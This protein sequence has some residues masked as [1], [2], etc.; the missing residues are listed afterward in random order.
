MAVIT[1]Q[2]RITYAGDNVSTVLAVPFEF[3]FAADLLVF[4]Q[5]VATGAYSALTLGT[6]YTAQNAGNPAGG[7]ITMTV[8]IVG[9]YNYSIIL[10]PTLTQQSNYP[11]NSPFPSG[12]VQNDFDRHMQISQRLLDQINRSIRAP[13]ADV[14]PGMLL[15]P[16]AQ[17]ISQ[18]LATDGAGN[19]I[20]TA[21]LPGTANT[22]ASLGPILNPQTAAEGIAGV[23]PTNFLFPPCYVDRYAINTTPGTTDM[24]PAFNAA[25]KVALVAGGRI[26]YGASGQYGVSSPINFTSGAGVASFGITV[27]CET[28]F[29]PGNLPGPSIVPN[30]T[31]HVIDLT[32]SLG[33]V[34][35]NVSIGNGSAIPKTGFFQS[36]LVAG[37]S[38][39]LCRFRNCST[40]G[41]FS[42]AAYY[43]YGAED[44]QL[45]DCYW[46]NSST[47]ANA[48]CIAWTGSNY[49]ALTSTFQTV[50]TGTVSSIDHKVFGGEIYMQSNT[51]TADCIHLEQSHSLK[52]YGPWMLCGTPSSGGGRSLIYVDMTN[53]GPAPSWV[54]LKNITGEENGVNVQQYGI[55]FSNNN[56]TPSTWD[57]DS[58]KLTNLSNT[59]A[60]G[61]AN[62]ILD[63]FRIRNIS[64]Q[65]GGAGLSV[66]ALQNS[67]VEG[68]PMALTIGISTKNVLRGFSDGWTIGTRV[69]DFWIDQGSGNKTIATVG[70]SGGITSSAGALIARARLS[71]NGPCLTFN[72]VLGSTSG[73]LAIAGGSTISL[74]APGGQSFAVSDSGSCTVV[75]TTAGTISGAAVSTSSTSALITIPVAVGSTPHTVVVSGTV[76]LA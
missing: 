49:A 14:G 9:G 64:Y 43:N 16:A 73:N 67:D 27:V 19:I 52:M 11:S 45:D 39:G 4:R 7:S 28:G 26:R 40:L 37:G 50:A 31:G 41:R 8:P 42:V 15:P 30:H 74:T 38:V 25:W 33:V 54:C 51:A 32:G 35:E 75:D 17:R 71:L 48:C 56:A 69:K 18:Y 13:D 6:D 72:I 55:L 5:L 36:R 53:P 57:I 2:D 12:T 47:A 44:D 62:P 20:V 21:A 23:V 63:N 22:A 29:V 34:F 70:T 60:T 1:T 68:G 61:G 66:S 58:C 24:S 3:F 46:N 10:S 59:I 76:F 65:A